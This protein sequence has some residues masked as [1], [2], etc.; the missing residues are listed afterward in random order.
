MRGPM[1]CVVL[2]LCSVAEAQELDRVTS[3]QLP[4]DNARAAAG[5]FDRALRDNDAPAF[6]ALLA[7]QLKVR[8]RSTSAKRARAAIKKSGVAGFPGA[9]V[10]CLVVG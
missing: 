5:E 4:D 2:L 9:E 7:E 10:R 6:Q 8:G 3:A 1:L